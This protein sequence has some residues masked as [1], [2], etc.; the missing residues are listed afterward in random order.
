LLIDPFVDQSYFLY[1]D[2]NYGHD[3]HD[4]HGD[5]VDSQN[6]DRRSHP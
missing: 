4:G 3:G 6:E 1:C 2:S 5:D